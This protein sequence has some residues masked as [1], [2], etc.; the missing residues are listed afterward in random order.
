MKHFTITINRKR[1]EISIEDNKVRKGQSRERVVP[2]RTSRHVPSTVDGPSVP[3]GS[4]TVERAPMPGTI[5][6]VRVAVGDSVTK[7]Q[8]LVVL[9]AMKMENEITSHADGVVS[10]VM[11][12]KGASV[13]NDDPLVAIAY[14]EVA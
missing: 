12:T 14:E 9:E 1:Y 3:T 11:V 2:Q 13:G 7:G 4:A 5:L 8:V 10:E 6:D